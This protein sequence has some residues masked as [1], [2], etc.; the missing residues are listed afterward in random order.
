MLQSRLDF[1][2]ITNQVELSLTFWKPLFD[3]TLDYLLENKKSPMAWSPFG[4]GKVFGNKSLMEKLTPLMLKYNCELSTLL[5]AWLVKL[6][7]KVFPV[8]GT[9]KSE[10]LKPIVDGLEL[11]LERQDWYIMLKHV[12]GYDVP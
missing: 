3:G 2:L 5:I 8:V 9:M 4:G 6:P 1:E 7:S 10:R 11:K 12:R